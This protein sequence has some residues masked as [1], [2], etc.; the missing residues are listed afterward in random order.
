MNWTIYLH[1]YMVLAS[2]KERNLY[3][4]YIG[5]KTALLIL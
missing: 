2:L 5:V 4:Q 3:V 1:M